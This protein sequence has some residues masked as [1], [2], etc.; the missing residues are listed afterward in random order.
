MHQSQ[1]VRGP[2]TRKRKLVEDEEKVAKRRRKEPVVR[3]ESP[4]FTCEPGLKQREIQDI[5]ESV[6]NVRKRKHENDV[7]TV[8]LETG[9]TVGKKDSVLSGRYVFRIKRLVNKESG[10]FTDTFMATMEF[11]ASNDEVYQSDLS[12]NKNTQFDI[13]KRFVNITFR[14]MT[15]SQ[16]KNMSES[17]GDV[18]HLFWRGENIRHIVYVTSIQSPVLREPEVGEDE[19]RT[20]L[21][22]CLTKKAFCLIGQVL[23]SYYLG[24]GYGSTFKQQDEDVS[25]VKPLTWE[26]TIGFVVPLKS[27]NKPGRGIQNR[28]DKLSKTLKI[29]FILVKSTTNPTAPSRKVL[30]NKNIIGFSI[31]LSD[32]LYAC[33]YR[34]TEDKGG[35]V[36]MMFTTVTTEYTVPE[37][38]MDSRFMSNK[39]ATFVGAGRYGRIYDIYHKGGGS[40][41]KDKTYVIKMI[42]IEKSTVTLDAFRSEVQ[43][44]ERMGENGIGPKVHSWWIC[45]SLKV[46]NLPSNVQSGKVDVIY[47]QGD[48]LS[49]GFVVMDK[50][51]MILSQYASINPNEFVKNSKRIEDLARDLITKMAG[52]GVEH[53]D[54][55]TGNIMINFVKGDERFVKSLRFIDFGRNRDVPPLKRDEAIVRMNREFIVAMDK[56]IERARAKAVSSA[57]DRE[58]IE[59]IIKQRAKANPFQLTDPNRMITPHITSISKTQRESS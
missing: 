58:A 34:K 52:L 45:D 18:E 57:T 51:D 40:V 37:Q 10:Q 35:D 2:T 36:G 9:I 30:F 21:N 42:V 56:H 55:H 43:V 48:T 31:V 15:V 11:K 20:L 13:D 23:K 1:P 5:L 17:P 49:A 39:I 6:F 4:E 16:Y 14:D 27:I 28:L 12:R 44:A 59:K 46:V 41:G 24:K 25:I 53:T 29:P 47:E 32:M 22:I 54:I 26:D 7:Q 3:K 33:G 38:C 50:M 19:S 8:T